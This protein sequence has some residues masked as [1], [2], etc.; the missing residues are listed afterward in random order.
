MGG[1]NY[2][3][4]NEL[5]TVPVVPSALSEH[6]LSRSLNEGLAVALAVTVTVLVGPAAASEAFRLANLFVASFARFASTPVPAASPMTATDKRATMQ[7]SMNTSMLH[8]H[9]TSLPDLL[10]DGSGSACCEKGDTAG[11]Y[12]DVAAYVLSM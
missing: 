9:I 1:K 7:E 2:I 8:P 6:P 3:H 10:V 5:Y 12:G 11:A 4:E